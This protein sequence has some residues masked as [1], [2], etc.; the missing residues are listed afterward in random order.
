MNL[1]LLANW[2]KTISLSTALVFGAF[3]QGYAQESEA[4]IVVFL[5]QKGAKP[6][7]A[8]AAQAQ[9]ISLFNQ[10]NHALFFMRR[11][12]QNTI[13]AIDSGIEASF[14]M[15]RSL[16]NTYPTI[17]IP[18]IISE[19]QESLSE[20]EQNTGISCLDPDEFTIEVHIIVEGMVLESAINQFE[21]RVR[22]IN[23]W[24]DTNGRLKEELNI[25][26]WRWDAENQRMNPTNN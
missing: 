17:D 1:Q 10:A 7:E 12:K 4:S 15:S 11:G 25:S 16:Y 24:N 21:R 14:E 20:F 5:P 2:L 18:S 19:F 13:V 8:D 9:A 22:L 23:G 6:G 3:G 26:R